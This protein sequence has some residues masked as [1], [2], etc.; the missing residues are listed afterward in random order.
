MEIVGSPAE[1]KKRRR[2]HSIN[3]TSSHSH[4][5]TERQPDPEKLVRNLGRRINPQMIPEIERKLVI[6]SARTWGPSSYKL[7][8]GPRNANHYTS[9]TTWLLLHIC[10]VRAPEAEC[11]GFGEDRW[12]IHDNKLT[13][14]LVSLPQVKFVT[15]RRVNTSASLGSNSNPVFEN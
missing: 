7:S 3:T 13:A 2:V 6:E 10:R 5:S 1:Q 15:N 14:R 11:W 12:F 4:T 9:I 8:K